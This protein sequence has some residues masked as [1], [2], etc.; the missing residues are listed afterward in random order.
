LTLQR[1]IVNALVTGLPEASF[2]HFS[3]YEEAVDDYLTARSKGCVRVARLSRDEE[4]VFGPEMYAED[5]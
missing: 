5:L 1:N 2:Q 3:T 4:S